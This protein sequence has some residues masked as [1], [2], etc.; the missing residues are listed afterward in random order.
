MFE[1]WSAGALGRS[2]ASRFS[3]ASRAALPMSGASEDDDQ[4]GPPCFCRLGGLAREDRGCVRERLDAVHVLEEQLPSVEAQ[5]GAYCLVGAQPLRVRDVA[6]VATRGRTTGP[7][8]PPAS[9]AS[10]MGGSWPWSAR[11]PRTR[12]A[13]GCPRPRRSRRP[14]TPRASRGSEARSPPASAEPRGEGRA[15]AAGRRSRVRLGRAARRACRS[16]GGGSNPSGTAGP[17][18]A[19][20][21]P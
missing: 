17:A 21:R 16:P 1:P 13:A 15:S 2:A 11:A 10:S 20:S 18:R 9:R 4:A 12:R 14:R 3:S 5:R 19:G 8:R 6:G 7:S